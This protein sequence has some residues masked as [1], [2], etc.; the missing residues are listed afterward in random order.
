M[1]SL[2]NYCPEIRL[3]LIVIAV[4]FI[5]AFLLAIVLARRLEM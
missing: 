4:Y 5:V 2:A 1:Y 3:S